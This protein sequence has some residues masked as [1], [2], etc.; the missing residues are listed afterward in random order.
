MRLQAPPEPRTRRRSSRELLLAPLRWLARAVVRLAGVE[1]GVDREQREFLDLVNEGV[2]E[3]G[4][5]AYGTP[6]VVVY[7]DGD[8][9]PLGGRVRI[10]PYCSIADG[11]TI[12][13]GG[14]HRLDWVSTF[15]FRV[16]FGLP[17]AFHDGHPASKG[18][19]TIGSDVWIGAGV[20]ILSG[21]TIG[22][23]AAIGANATVTSDVL[24]YAVVAGNPAREIRRRFSDDEI[25]FLLALRWWD[26][27]EEQVREA[28]PA[29][30][31]PGLDLLRKY[32]DPS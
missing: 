2:V 22:D 12:M 20:T 16:R 21:V 26:W 29:L 14:G 24:P 25:E 19:V 18:D 8:D 31:S 32:V 15:P 28:I 3:L 11:V 4:T 6:R 1:S 10:G 5:H 9:R 13:T 27:P 23:G 7:R 17:G 30:C